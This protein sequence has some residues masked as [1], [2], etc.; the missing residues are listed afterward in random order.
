MIIHSF[1]EKALKSKPLSAG[2]VTW[3]VVVS[4]PV[5]YPDPEVQLHNTASDAFT[6]KA[7]YFNGWFVYI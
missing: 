7:L 5:A 1:N 3:Q 4:W 6:A 2:S